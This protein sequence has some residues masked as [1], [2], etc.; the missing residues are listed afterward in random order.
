MKHKKFRITEHFNI[1]VSLFSI[2]KYEVN[3]EI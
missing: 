3:E 1:S 2:V